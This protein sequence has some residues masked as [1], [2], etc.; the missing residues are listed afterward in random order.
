VRPRSSVGK[1]SIAQLVL[2]AIG[3]GVWGYGVRTDAS[4]IRWIG[5]GFFAGAAVLWVFRGRMGDDGR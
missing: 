3:L 5:I 1:R 4:G 2:L